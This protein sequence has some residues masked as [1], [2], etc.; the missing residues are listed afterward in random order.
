[1]I[2]GYDG[3]GVIAQYEARAEQLAKSG[4]EIR[5]KGYCM[6]ACTIM[7]TRP[8]VNTCVTRNAALGFHRGTYYIGSRKVRFPIEYN[9]PVQTWINSRGG[10]PWDGSFLVMTWPD[11]GIYFRECGK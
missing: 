8:G 5:V 11:T 7:I 4:E 9:H 6:S 1:M 3:G 2:I 10:L